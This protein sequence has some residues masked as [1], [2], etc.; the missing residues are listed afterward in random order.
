MKTRHWNIEVIDKVNPDYTPGRGWFDGGLRG[1][2]A[3]I[4][5][6]F[7]NKKQPRGASGCMLYYDPERYII[8]V[9]TIW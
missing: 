3:H 5:K 9:T 2:K 8:K 6:N 7:L 4:K 1:L